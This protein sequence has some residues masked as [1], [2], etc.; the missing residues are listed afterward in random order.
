MSPDLQACI[1]GGEGAQ[2]PATLEEVTPVQVNKLPLLLTQA[3]LMKH[4]ESHTQ[5]TQSGTGRVEKG[6]GGTKEN[7]VDFNPSTV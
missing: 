4:S 5:E 6:L 2:T 7:G 1:L 3:T